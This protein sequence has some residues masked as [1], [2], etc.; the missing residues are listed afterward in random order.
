MH[1]LRDHRVTNWFWIDNKVVDQ[2]AAK[3]KPYAILVYILLCRMANDTNKCWPSLE[4]IA[5][6]TNISRKSVSVALGELVKHGLVLVESGD[7]SGRS[8]TYTLLPIKDTDTPSVQHTHPS[9]CPTHPSVQGTHPSV[10]H[11]L[12]LVYGVHTNN[13][14]IT[15]PIN[16]TNICDENTTSPKNSLKRTIPPEQADVVEYCKSR[17]STVDPYKWF[18][19]YASKGWMIGKTKMK[20]W[21][22]AVRTW[23]R[24][25]ESSG[26]SNTSSALRI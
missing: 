14:N 9:V 1:E 12:P 4:T 10:R 21:Q 19:F 13:T 8:N 22:A 18:D 3:L 23:E 2:Y 11:D 26:Y 25:N 16:N 24:T 6:R 17:N 20:D 5:K 15:I 7:I